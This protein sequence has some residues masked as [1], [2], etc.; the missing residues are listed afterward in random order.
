[1]NEKTFQMRLVREDRP[2]MPTDISRCSFFCAMNNRYS[3]AGFT[4]VEMAIVLVIV[5]LL[6][7]GLLVP[8]ATQKEQQRRS[9]NA[10]MLDEAVQALIG[11]AT[12]HGRLPCPDTD[13]LTS[14]NRGQENFCAPTN[15]LP[16]Y[17]RLPWVTLGINAEFDPWGDGTVTHT[18]RYAVHGAYV[19]AIALD[20][21][22]L[23]SAGGRTLEVHTNAA[24][25]GSAANKV[26][27]NVPAVVWTTAKNDYAASADEVK[28]ATD[29]ECFVSRQHS[30]NAAT[31][32]DDQLVW[33]SPAILFNRMI[34]AGKLP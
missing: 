1:M 30:T 21:E 34:S 18:V 27:M 16:Y 2:P 23:A 25:C 33:I 4:I 24:D 7:G 15:A 6:I 17:G 13:A 19:G 26:A 8:L 12:V 28:N 3:Q 29:D 14:P 10:A 32:F 31:P 22:S 9:D 11:F 5:G 20:A